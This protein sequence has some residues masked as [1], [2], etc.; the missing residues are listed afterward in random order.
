VAEVEPRLRRALVASLGSERGREALV[1]ALG[2]A[3][4][5]R[6]SLA[7]LGQP[8]SFLYRVGQSRTRER[9]MPTVVVAY[10]VR[11]HRRPR[12]IASTV[13]PSIVRSTLIDASDDP[14]S[15]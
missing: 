5:H 8:V 1:E 2:W 11:L 13:Q 6:G 7:D 14:R 3:W 4:E 12:K 9:R 15:C 10:E